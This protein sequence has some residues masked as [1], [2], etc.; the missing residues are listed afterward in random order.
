MGGKVLSQ[1]LHPSTE[2][3]FGHG[4]HAVRLKEKRWRRFLENDVAW[5]CRLA[6]GTEIASLGIGK[7]Y[8]ASQFSSAIIAV[9]LPVR[10]LTRW[11]AEFDHSCRR[12]HFDE[13]SS[14]LNECKRLIR[15][16]GVEIISERRPSPL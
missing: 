6:A 5:S 4:I 11:A 3:R 2:I 9:D 7:F 12:G 14:I 8:S 15:T 10:F 1:N 16:V 13:D